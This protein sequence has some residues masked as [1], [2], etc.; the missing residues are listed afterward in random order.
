MKKT[1]TG[2]YLRQLLH[3]IGKFVDDKQNGKRFTITG[4]KITNYQKYKKNETQ[5]VVFLV[6]AFSPVS[7]FLQIKRIILIA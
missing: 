5:P 2:G 1:R 7:I 4:G 3:L 6:T